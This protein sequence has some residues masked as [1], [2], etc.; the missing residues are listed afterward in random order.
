MFKE[1]KKEI[2]SWWW[3][4]VILII[5]T[6]P[7]FTMLNYLG[8]IGHTVVERTVFENSFQ[9]KE[10]MA[11]RY[12]G[13]S[14]NLRCLRDMADGRLGRYYLPRLTIVHRYPAL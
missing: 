7:I 10:G 8:I 4:F 11:Q 2:K 12:S 6:I 14:H 1:E 9:Y 13:L 5:L 3:F